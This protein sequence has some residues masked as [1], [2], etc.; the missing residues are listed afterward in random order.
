MDA[1]AFETEHNQSTPQT[2]GS[3]MEASSGQ[4]VQNGVPPQ[5][6]PKRSKE[7]VLEE[8]QRESKT[9]RPNS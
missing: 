2:L 5:Q 4:G 8:L 6:R 3:I 9:L 1:L 7:E